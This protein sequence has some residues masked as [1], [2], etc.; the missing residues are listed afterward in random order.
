[1][2]MTDLLAANF[3]SNLDL[4]KKHLADFTDADMLV[5]PVPGAN[6][7]A[8]Q[9]GHLAVFEVMLCGI[10]A[11]EA[12]LKLPDGSDKTYGKE[13]A[14]SDDAGHFFK[15]DEGPQILTDAC[16]AL[17]GWVKTRTDAD[18]A[19]PAPEQFRGWVPTEG[20]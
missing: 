6:H 15:K 4:L 18:L 14:A 11:P 8:W 13:G 7:A 16:D 20:I 5:R 3:A 19:K 1:M 2:A 10:F 12:G 9:I 17:A